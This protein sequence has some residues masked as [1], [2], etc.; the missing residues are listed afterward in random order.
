MKH[1]FSI[2]DDDGSQDGR[3][4]S[5]PNEI[6]TGDKEGINCAVFMHNHVLSRNLDAFNVIQLSLSIATPHQEINDIKLQNRDHTLIKA[7]TNL[8]L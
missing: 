3:R 7:I 4:F 2:D 6:E 8:G 5:T 1:C